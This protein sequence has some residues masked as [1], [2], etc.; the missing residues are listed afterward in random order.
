MS[1]LRAWFTDAMK[2]ALVG[3]DD[4]S[5]W[6]FRGGL[7]RA[8]V[9][10]GVDVSVIVPA[11]NYRVAIESLGARCLNVPMSRFVTPASDVL[12]TWRLFRVFR[13][14]R[15]DI[16]HNMT[17][18][19]NIF[20]TFAAW[21]AGVRRRVCL[22]SGLGF[23]FAERASLRGRFVR[24]VVRTLYRT[25]S[26]LSDKTWFQNPDDFDQFVAERLI[27]REKG[28]VIRSS[29][30]NLDTFHAG[31]VPSESL[32]ALREEFGVPT[33]NRWVLMVAARL[34]WSKGVREFVEAA[35][36]LRG[37]HPDWTFV[38][39]APPD[40]GSPDA[41]PRSWIDENQS[42]NLIVV[43][44]F[45]DDIQRFLASSDVVVLASYY[46]EGVPRSLLEGMAMSKPIVTCDSVGC[47]EVVEH[48]RNGFLIP[49]RDSH[50]LAARLDELMRDERLREAFGRESLA[51]ATE[52][53]DERLVVR[54]VLS[55]LYRL[56]EPLAMVE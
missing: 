27:P 54:E 5:V 24:A 45:R 15:F 23:V 31:V 3:N 43:D 29:G 34:V 35:H 48:G 21:A 12:L 13:R 44:R 28:V 22:V 7:I 49:V 16:V 14:E 30:V 32:S 17:V 37:V 38:M 51:M 41:V 19:P 39:V 6:H 4:F 11:G 26:K 36:R 52:L 55:Q 47:R 9:S 42:E 53:F 56:D 10:R 18:K 8:L 40:P 46:R 25:A 20:G 50:A 33:G 2:V 1:P